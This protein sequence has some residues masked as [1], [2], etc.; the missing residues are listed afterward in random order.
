MLVMLAIDSLSWIELLNRVGAVDNKAFHRRD[1]A[2]HTADSGE[3]IRVET[4]AM[5]DR[6]SPVDRTVA[7]DRKAAHVARSMLFGG[8]PATAHHRRSHRR[9]PACGAPEARDGDG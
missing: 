9:T 6:G 2:W 1:I 3:L 5:F 4:G 8:S 7:D